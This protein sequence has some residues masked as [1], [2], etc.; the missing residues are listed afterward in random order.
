MKTAFIYSGQ[1]AKYKLSP[2]HPYDP[3]R[4]NRC[5]DLIR[6][7]NLLDG[8]NQRLVEPSPLPR[9]E[10]ALAH[11]EA[12]LQRLEQANA[13]TFT[14]EMLQ[15]GLGSQDCPVFPGVLDMN[16]LAAGATWR[17][18]ELVADGEC[19]F[20]FNPMGGY[21]H[22]GYAVAEGFCYINDIVI[23]ARKLLARG[24]RI[25]YIDI[26]AHH[27]N[28][29]QDAFYQDNR[30][31]TISLHE[32]GKSLYP[33]TGFETEIGEGPGRGYSVNVPLEEMSDDEVFFY[34]FS[35]V[36]PPLVKAFQ[37]DLVI[38]VLGVD[39]MATDPL[40]HL[41]MTN[42]GFADICAIINQISPRWIG[43]G[44][45]GYNL[46]NVARGWTLAWAVINN[47]ENT[48]QED[49][50]TLGGMFLG[51]A[52]LGLAAIRDM[53]VYTTGPA[54]DLAYRE[55]DRVISYLK[56]HVFPILGAR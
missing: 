1:F 7:F 18:A 6:R 50:L 42:N 19:Q 26:D 10:L 12:Y 38:G 2:L 5:Y 46:D 55:A 47:L 24:M 27:G 22:A 8:T 34:A 28:G 13:G 29:V 37:P 56:D 40:T 43:L 51:E 31:L 54:K 33:G 48:G 23:A 15:Y 45:G 25:A 30:V 44:A 4:A 53:H 36:V 16:L 39:T 52:D 49:V 20:A 3:I 9:S 14:L 21:H 41:R 32:T 11:S 17:A 35:E